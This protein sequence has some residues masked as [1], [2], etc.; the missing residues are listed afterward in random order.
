M[1]NLPWW[2]VAL[3][4]FQALAMALAAWYGYRSWRVVR[5]LRACRRARAE[6]AEHLGAGRPLNAHA[7]FARALDEME[8]AERHKG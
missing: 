5:H 1:G 2:F 7:A 3:S 4:A 6:A 8:K